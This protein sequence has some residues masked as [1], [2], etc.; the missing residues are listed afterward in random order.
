MVGLNEERAKAN[1]LILKVLNGLK[2]SDKYPEMVDA[3]EW[4]IHE[5]PQQRASQIFC[6]YI[7]NDYRNKEVSKETQEIMNCLFPGDYDPFY[8][9]PTVTLRRLT[10]KLIEEQLENKTHEFLSLEEVIRSYAVE[11][12]LNSEFKEKFNKQV[13]FE[14][15]RNCKVGTLIGLRLRRGAF[16]YIINCNNE[17]VYIPISNSITL[18]N[19]EE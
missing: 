6:N 19:K 17:K 3:Y 12:P 10:N 2:I 8:E 14:Y 7:C 5:Y 18:L 9:E 1:K 13:F 4:L 15:K 16:H 11:E